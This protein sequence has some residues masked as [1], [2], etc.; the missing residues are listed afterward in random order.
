M[1]V[2][3]DE[4]TQQ[5]PLE[6]PLELPVQLA[7]ALDDKGFFARALATVADGAEIERL[8][9]HL[10]VLLNRVMAADRLP[11]SD[12]EGARTSLERSV[13]YLGLALEFLAKGDPAR[14]GR[15]LQTIALERIFR[16]GVSLTLQ[17]QKL[18]ATLWNK[19][20][21][22]LD[23]PF[24]ALVAA[25]RRRRPQRADGA[26]FRTLA[27]IG[28]TAASLKEAAEAPAL[29]HDG[30]GVPPAEAATRIAEAAVPEEARFGTLARTLAAHIVLQQAPT[31][32]P[33]SPPEVAQVARATMQERDAAF[34]QLREVMIARG[35]PAEV[36][37]R[38]LARWRPL[39]DT[40]SDAGAVLTRLMR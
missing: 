21:P 7:S 4:G 25:L 6:Q 28:E 8:Q 13:G 18:A 12:V 10:M 34:A 26:S 27:E 17:L 14:A 22:L 24:D 3:I 35:A 9:G 31:L 39:L 29:L 5:P 30:L 2:K 15:A 19:V 33:L 32:T 16:V 11:A 36:A 20:G 1:S 37:D 40:P 38:W 23:P